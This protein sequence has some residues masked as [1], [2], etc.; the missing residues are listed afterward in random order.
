MENGW[1]REQY[2]IFRRYLALIP[3]PLFLN[4]GPISSY[5]R[6]LPT[7]TCR[8]IQLGT[9]GESSRE[10]DNHQELLPNIPHTTVHSEIIPNEET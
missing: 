1:I 6:I 10:D 3:F 5:A 2:G 9:G 8:G 7:P 4:F